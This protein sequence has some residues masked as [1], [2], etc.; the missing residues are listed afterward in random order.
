MIGWSA[1]IGTLKRWGG[2]SGKQESRSRRCPP[3]LKCRRSW[4]ECHA[5]QGFAQIWSSKSCHFESLSGL[6]VLE[7]F[8]DFAYVEIFLFFPLSKRLFH[9]ILPFL[10]LASP[11]PRTTPSQTSRHGT[12]ISSSTLAR[13]S[14]RRGE[15]Q[16]YS[17]L[18]LSSTSN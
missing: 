6:T 9:L 15:L 5:G 3:W 16:P 14:S 12:A 7:S 4:R 10:S 17:T 13:F 1:S 11:S 18:L 8:Q 2:S